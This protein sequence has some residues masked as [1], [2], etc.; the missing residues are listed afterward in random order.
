MKKGFVLPSGIIAGLLLIAGVWFLSQDS[1]Q[2]AVGLKAEVPGGAEFSSKRLRWEWERQRDPATNM[3]PVGIKHRERAFVAA[4]RERN[5]LP[6]FK[7][8]ADGPFNW[9]QRGPWNVGGRTR[10]LAFD[11]TGTDTI[12]AGGISGGM[13]RSSDGGA[14]WT[15]TTSPDQ[16]IGVSAVVQD[17]RPGK[18]HIWYYGTGEAGSSASNFSFFSLYVGNGMFKSTDNGRTWNNLSATASGTPQ[19]PDPADVIWRVAMD[20]SNT[21]EDEVYC[22]IQGAIRR[23]SDGGETWTS[24]IRTSGFG[25]TPNYYA[26]VAVTSTGVVYVTMSGDGR[27]RGIYRSDDGMTFTDITPENFGSYRRI[28][29]GLAPSNTDVVYFLAET[30]GRGKVGKNFRGDSAF[31]SFWKYTYRSG[32]GT[33]AGGEWEDRSDNLPAYGG[34]FGDF[35]SQGGYDLLVK[36]KPDDE[37]AVFIGGTNLYRSTDGFASGDNTAWI[38]G[39]GD[40]TLNIEANPVIV[41][42]DYPKHH[43]D[44]HDVVFSPTDPNVLLSASDGGVHKTVNCLADSID[45]ISLNNGYLSTQFYTVAIN[46]ERSGDH[47]IVGGTQ[48]NGTW[49]GNSVEANASWTYT[50][51]GDGAFAGVANDGSFLVVSK[52]SGRVYRV[53]LDAEGNVTGSTRVDPEGPNYETY[54]FIN[55]LV[56]DPNDS[57]ALFLPVSQHI[58]INRDIT[59]IPLNNERPTP[60]GWDSIGASLVTSGEI[61]AV[62]VSD[63]NPSHRL[64]YGTNTGLVYRMDDALGD[65]P[66]PVEVTPD[67]F[68][69]NRYISCIA[70]DPEN[71]DR[72][73]VVFSNYSVLSLYQ[74]TDAGETWESISGNLEELPNGTGAGPS[75]RWLSILHRGGRTLYLVGTSSGLF[76]TTRLNG[77]ETHWQ[78]E[79]G[80]TIGNTVVDMIDVRQS[81][82]FVAVGTHGS[83]IY[84]ATIGLLGVDENISSTTQLAFESVSPNPMSGQGRIAWSF[85]GTE[86]KSRDVRLE[87]L[88]VQGRSVAT[89]RGEPMLSGRHTETLDT[90]SL[91][92]GTYFLRLEVD[93]ESVVKSLIVRR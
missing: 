34:S 35:H 90:R 88:D 75:C 50:G 49:R 85:G 10:G 8:A 31:H 25:T 62:S 32:D 83:G 5:N 74:T 55:P 2:E 91:S 86:K 15:R 7:S 26:D 17:T 20:P 61:T 89:L 43:P 58:W 92:Q 54:R 39:Y 30:P 16:L 45:W 79:A 60:I 67:N 81:D 38:G 56:L 71:G 37:N 72:A 66:V 12:L 84:A 57:K 69:G 22:A 47:T 24:V 27:T 48:D 42:Y 40:F 51:S 3:I 82:G 29:I 33:G 14:S 21:E 63:E 93:G 41:R 73:I 76:S 68:P 23:S 80:E 18:T 9:E 13:W 28:T 64:W 11:V 52:Q 6:L 77:D 78:Q 44:Q 4:L 1:A 87:L 70:P 46:R 53:D 65:N 59:A 36:V 19:N